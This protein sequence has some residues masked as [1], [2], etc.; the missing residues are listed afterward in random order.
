[1]HSQKMSQHQMMFVIHPRN[2]KQGNHR[3]TTLEHDELQMA[4]HDYISKY[5]VDALWTTINAH[6]SMNRTSTSLSHNDSGDAVM[7]RDYQQQISPSYGRI[8]EE[9]EVGGDAEA[10]LRIANI[11]TTSITTSEHGMMRKG[12]RSGPK[13]ADLLKAA[14]ERRLGRSL[15]EARKLVEQQKR[16]R[17]V[18][19]EKGRVMSIPASTPPASTVKFVSPPSTL[20]TA[21]PHFKDPE[22]FSLIKTIGLFFAVTPT[23]MTVLDDGMSEHARLHIGTGVLEMLD[24]LREVSKS[25]SFMLTATKSKETLSL[26]LSLDDPNSQSH[27]IDEMVVMKRLY[28]VE[29]IITSLESTCTCISDYTW[30]LLK[31]L[32]NVID[33]E[34]EWRVGHAGSAATLRLFYDN[35]SIIE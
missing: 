23:S 28:S 5:G 22:G 31:R 18:E 26:A 7:S 24:A 17:A 19:E 34:G 32:M 11:Q 33:K 27:L 15:G 12:G 4:V 10:A 14:I 6:K 25:P 3:M 9:L 29:N 16:M 1:M 20:M 8:Q 2:L 21:S 13:K 30:C 35:T